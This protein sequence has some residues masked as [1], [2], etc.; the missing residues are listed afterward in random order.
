MKLK[1]TTIENLQEK[2]ILELIQQA[3]V[4]LIFMFD[5]KNNFIDEYDPWSGISAAT[6]FASISTYH[7]MSQATLSQLVFRR[8]MILN[9]PFVYE[10][11]DISIRKEE[12]MDKNNQNNNKNPK[13]HNYR[14]HKKVLM[15]N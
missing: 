3:V 6:Y 5:L 7:T 12:L 4:N 10:W 9:T 11:G 2:S 8:D 14:V 13:L 1:Y 15:S